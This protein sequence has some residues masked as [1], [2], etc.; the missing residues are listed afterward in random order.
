V[1]RASVVDDDYFVIVSQLSQSP[2]GKHDKARDRSGIIVGG[3]EHA[4][5]WGFTHR[6]LSSPLCR[7]ENK[8]QKS[9]HSYW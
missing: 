5:A 4:D 8:D 3:K 6:A 7:R 2:V 9:D 1:I